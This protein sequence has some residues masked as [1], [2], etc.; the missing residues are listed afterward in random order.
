[1]HRELIIEPTSGLSA[2]RLREIWEYR[3]LFYFLVWRDIKIR[4]KQTFLG[5]SWA[6]IRPVISMGVFTFLFHNLAGFSAPGVPYQLFTFSGILAWSFFSEGLTGASQSLVANTNLITKVYF[7]RMI[8]P[9]AA[10]LRG[11]VD[12][13]IAFGIYLILLVWF[14]YAPG[15]QILLTPFALLWGI[16][17]SLGVG[18]WFTAIGV[19]YRDVAHALP[20]VAQILFWIT[21]VGYSSEKVPAQ[22]EWLY[23]LNPMT[24]VIE[25]FR[26]ALLGVAHLPP[27]LVALSLVMS[28]AIFVT[29][30]LNFRRLEKEFADVI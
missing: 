20:F 6:I 26:Y 19:K 18:L 4:Y 10:V 24:G 25:F 15:W 13:A 28:I 7:P 3:E 5:A 16:I 9:S 8:I 12:F 14:Q 17:A 11:V 2:L 23:W 27:A 30:V 29:G 1:M 21:P 22:W